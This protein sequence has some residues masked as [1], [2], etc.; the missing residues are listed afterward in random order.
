[1]K[2]K[3]SKILCVALALL[4][5]LPAVV[6]PVGVEEQLV[7]YAEAEDGD[8]LLDINFKGDYWSKDFE[9]SDN[10]DANITVSEDGKSLNIALIDATNDR[11]MW[12]GLLDG[13]K[14]PLKEAVGGTD[15]EYKYNKYTIMFDA[16]FGHNYAGFGVKIDRNHVL[17]VNGYGYCYWYSWNTKLVDKES[18]YSQWNWNIEGAKTDKQT[19][20]VEVDP[21]NKTMSL[22]VKD[23]EGYGIF[24]HVRTMTVESADFGESLECQLY[25][26]KTTNSNPTSSYTI[27][28]SDVKLYK[29]LVAG[30]IETFAGASVHIEDPSA[31]RFYS[32]FR[33]AT[34]D[35]LRETYGA[36]NVKLGMIIAPTSYITNNGIDFEISALD[37]FAADS[38][39]DTYFKIDAVPA[40]ED[41]T[42]YTTHCT[43]DPVQ[44][45][46]YGRVFSARSYIEVNGEIYKYSDFDLND[47]SRSI[48]EVVF[49]AL[50]DVKSSTDDEYKYS[51]VVNG[52]TKYSP[53]SK[54]ARNTL[55]G[56]F[57]AYVQSDFASSISTMTYN[58]EMYK[59]DGWGGRNISAAT[60][61][62][63]DYDPDVV[64]LQED[65]DKWRKSGE[66]STLT[67]N[68]YKQVKFSGNGSENLDIFYKSDKF[69]LVKSGQ[70]SFK[71]LSEGDYSD[72]D[73]KGADFS[74]DESGDKEIIWLNGKKVRRDKGR[75][76]SYVV[77]KD[78][79]AGVEFLVV[80][81]HFHYGDGTGSADKY[82]D[83]NLV[84][85]YEARILRAWL[86]DM[87]EEYPNQIVIGDMNATPTT[88]T[89]S[90]FSMNGGMSF[91]K[92]DA[93]VK[94]DT[95]GTLVSTSD[96]LRRDKY[97]FDHIIY[98]NVVSTEY[99]VVDNKTDEVNGE[100]RYPS[101]HLPVY[102]EFVC[103]RQ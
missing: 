18:G 73:P 49:S 93:L 16:D 74:I 96:Y 94:K 86:D 31:I 2:N 41:S 12:G 95:G 48:A 8:L 62:I 80:N 64:G 75:M 97:V 42:H 6:L 27:D 25:S 70:E 3:I 61:T 98:R 77:L 38:D 53:Y 33:K 71:K 17:V 15:G 22:Y 54:N 10:S 84:R 76:F 7:D 30:Q 36:D 69:D 1:M 90:E 57:T 47:H 14:Y 83:D 28:V 11:A 82:V 44:V 35:S 26:T 46:D 72:V 5:T 78:K 79:N 99:T 24:N 51:T 55:D 67:A 103:T 66:Y 100:M 37:A 87:E 68:G 9:N 60:K 34:I 19:F 4:M 23:Y 45:N 63:I 89:I 43:L 91:A 50:G 29:G 81:T 56:I 40:Y 59:E 20:A 13:Y 52:A 21:E 39:E 101:D 58:I 92:N 102:A 65:D 88:S 32:Q 85:D